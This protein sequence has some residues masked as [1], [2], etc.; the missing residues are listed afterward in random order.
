MP[1]RQTD[2]KEIAAL[3]A[4]ILA[5]R[6]EGETVISIHGDLNARQLATDCYRS[7]LEWVRKLEG[8]CRELPEFTGVNRS[9]ADRPL[10]AVPYSGVVS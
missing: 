6:A 1:N 5:R 9:V 7:F 3:G 4:E 2:L 8:D 10:V